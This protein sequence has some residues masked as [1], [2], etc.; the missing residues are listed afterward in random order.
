MKIY[1]EFSELK[2]QDTNDTKYTRLRRDMIDRIDRIRQNEFYDFLD[3][4]YSKYISYVS[5]DEFNYTVSITEK[6]HRLSNRI[7]IPMEVLSRVQ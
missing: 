5:P 4:H 3:E 2:Y 6:V 1:I 7:Q